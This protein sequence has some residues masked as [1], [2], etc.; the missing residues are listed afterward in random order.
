ML[1]AEHGAD[2]WRSVLQMNARAW[3]ELAERLPAPADLY[4]GRLGEI[5]APVL[6]VH[7]SGDP[8]TEPGELEAICAA[9]PERR[10][11][12][13]TAPAT[14]RT[15]SA[16]RRRGRRQSIAAFVAEPSDT[17][18]EGVAGS[19]RAARRA[20]SYQSTARI[21]PRRATPRASRAPNVAGV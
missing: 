12:S 4:E 18:A 1:A 7:G 21:V 10:G 6:I 13:W 9:L 11:R 16:T 14:A 3:L 15:A 8:R 19:R 2:R 5:A 17:R 20:T